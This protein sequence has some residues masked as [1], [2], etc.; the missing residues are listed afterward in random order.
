MIVAAS[1]WLAHFIRK[2]NQKA[3]S[4]EVLVYGIS[5][6]LHSVATTFIILFFSLITAHLMQGFIAIASFVILR[7]FSGGAHLHSSWKCDVCSVVAI[8]SIA[9]IDYSFADYGWVT[10]GIALLLVAIFSPNNPNFTYKLVEKHSG[11]LK[12]ISI[13]I[14]AVN[15][16]IQSSVVANA[17][18][19][20]SLTLT[21]PFYLLFKIIDRR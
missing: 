13:L 12:W 21:K 8:L 6:F 11:K 19:L 20:Q 18:L 14:V 7:I 1:Q 3:A 10:N 15:F 9:H 4:T 2:H 16:M 17:F 5:V